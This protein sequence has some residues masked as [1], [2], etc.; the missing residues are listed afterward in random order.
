MCVCTLKGK[1]TALEVWK[2]I[3]IEH[4]IMRRIMMSGKWEDMCVCV[5]VCDFYLNIDDVLV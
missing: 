5:C 2:K 3:T 4:K 1:T